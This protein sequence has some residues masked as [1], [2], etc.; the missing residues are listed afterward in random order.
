MEVRWGGVTD[1]GG[2]GDGGSHT[3]SPEHRNTTQ[4]DACGSNIP[5]ET[6]AVRSAMGWPRRLLSE[7]PQVYSTPS[8]AH[9]TGVGRS[10]RTARHGRS[11]AHCRGATAVTQPP[12][13]TQR[14]T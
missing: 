4:H 10:K 12:R 6:V 14:R 9:P 11:Q 1:R 2:V 8:S 13:R 7:E 5:L 3:P